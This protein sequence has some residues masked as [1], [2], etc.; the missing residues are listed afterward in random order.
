MKGKNKNLN[1]IKPKVAKLYINLAFYLI[2]NVIME[3][4]KLKELL[5]KYIEL[6]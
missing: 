3:K 5:D 6:V 2:T 4:D 1:N